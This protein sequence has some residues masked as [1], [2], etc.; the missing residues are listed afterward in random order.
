MGIWETVDFKEYLQDRD[1]SPRTVVGYLQ[2]IRSFALWFQKQNAQ[3]L[4]PAILTPIDVRNYRAYLI[5]AK[6]MPASINRKLMAI[7]A[8]GQWGISTGEI[9]TN[10]ASAI[11]TMREQNHAPKW[12][13]KRQQAK[14][15]R[16]VERDLAI[17]RTYP[18]RVRANRDRLII[19]LLMHAGLRVSEL[20]HLRA[21]DLQVSEKAGRVNVLGKGMK[22]RIVPLNAEVRFA[23]KTWKETLGIAIAPVD[24]IFVGD[25]GLGC[26]T[27]QGVH[28]MIAEYGRRA[29]VPVSPHTLR[30]TFAKNLIDAGIPLDQ[31]AM[32]LGH[33]RLE[34]TRIYTMPGERDLEMAVEKLE[35]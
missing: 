9:Q 20:C 23:L 21:R 29:Q 32:L 28:A 4:A 5:D 17:V 8:Y 30:H 7:R 24:Y 14:L 35:M 31:V 2:E 18:A 33:A 6:Q 16:E 19:V 34:T 1:L 12:L 13:D 10:P 25:G 27:R 3:E 11:H 15:L 26:I 22:V